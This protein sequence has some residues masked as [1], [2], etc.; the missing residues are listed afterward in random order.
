MTRTVS[1][2]FTGAL[3]LFAV[4]PAS[5][6][7]KYALIVSGASGGQEY[8]QKYDRLRSTLVAA[9]EQKLNYPADHVVVLAE[10]EGPGIAKSTRENVQRA[11]T[12]LR[13]RV[14]KDD[15]LLVVLIGHGTAIDG[16][17]AKFNLPGPDLS[18]SD[19]AELTKPIAGRLVFVNT[20]GASFA[21][22]HRMAG[23]NRIVMTATD[24]AAQQFETVFPE[25]F[26][27]AFD[28][29]AA[30]ADKNGRISLWEAFSYASAGVH[31]YYEQKGT[32]PTERALLDDTGAGIG[33]EALTPG[34]D[35]ALA[36]ATFVEAD[37]PLAAAAASDAALESLIERRDALVDEL[38]QLK[39]KKNDIPEEHYQAELERILVELARVSQQIRAKS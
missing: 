26:V 36:R 3:T 24:S 5:A 28:D 9:L 2:L 10:E 15:V 16:E 27:K 38:E 39:A 19:W 22:L 34:P 23:K 13:R 32:L 33:R 14:G 6:A 20:T 1:A 29:P 37:S 35:G 25:Y 7:E 11:A 4:M 30:D 12:D 8:A 17:D 18:A 31:Q 21:F